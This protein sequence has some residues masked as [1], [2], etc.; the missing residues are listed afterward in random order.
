MN[1]FVDL[2]RRTETQGEAYD[3]TKQDLTA[4]LDS[5]F[6]AV[7]LFLEGFDVVVREP[8]DAKDE[9]GDDHQDGVDAVKLTHQQYGDQDGCDD[10]DATHGRDAN[11]LGVIRVD[12]SI[13]LGLND[14]FTLQHLD[15]PVAKPYRNYKCK[16]NGGSSAEGDIGEYACSGEVNLV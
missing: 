16:D 6:D 12:G 8:N 9:S 15:E 10:D 4:K 1:V 5:G 14:F 7:F 3:Q 11:L 2:H 13:A